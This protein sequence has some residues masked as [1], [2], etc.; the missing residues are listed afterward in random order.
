M[1]YIGDTEVGA[2]VNVGAGTITCNYDGVNKHRT[3]IGDGASIG[4]NVNLVAPVEIGK[5]AT[6]GAGSTITK[7]VE[8]NQLALE[9][10]KQLTVAGWK[11]PVKKGAD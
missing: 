8:D 1:T 7:P 2:D 9:R 11:R 5:G 10:S 3:K 6:V 4:S